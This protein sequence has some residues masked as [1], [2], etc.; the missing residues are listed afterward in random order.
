[1]PLDVYILLY[2][3]SILQIRNRG[4]ENPVE[5]I[6]VRVNNEEMCRQR[7]EGP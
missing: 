1:M 2:R 3:T 5:I 6:T 7:F 4:T